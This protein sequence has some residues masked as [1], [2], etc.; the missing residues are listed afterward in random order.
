V[1][2]RDKTAFPRLLV[3]ATNLT[4]CQIEYFYGDSSD[5]ELT[6][7]M[8]RES[9]PAWK[10]LQFL[11]K[12][13]EDVKLLKRFNEVAA[14]MQ[15]LESLPNG[16]PLED[17][18]AYRAVKDRGYLRVPRIVSIMPPEATTQFGD[19]DFSPEA[20]NERADRGEEQTLKALEQLS[21]PSTPAPKIARRRR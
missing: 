10:N 21:K 20:I 11:N 16:N 9:R 6:K 15:A 12:S 19:A 14:L 17:H 3:S 1:V 8:P 5:Y 13:L 4:E 2:E 18:P 7:N